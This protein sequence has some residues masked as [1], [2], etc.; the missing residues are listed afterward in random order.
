[1]TRR[2]HDGRE[3]YVSAYRPH[4]GGGITKWTIGIGA[5]IAEL[6]RDEV[7]SLALDIL[8]DIASN[9]TPPELRRLLEERGSRPEPPEAA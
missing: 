7:F 9:A 1:M 6:D 2:V 5:R 4:V 3:V 8:L